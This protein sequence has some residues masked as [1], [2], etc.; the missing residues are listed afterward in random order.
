VYWQ[1]GEGLT[2]VLLHGAGDQ[3]GTWSEIVPALLEEYRLL[4]PDLPGHGESEPAQGPLPMDEIFAGLE[5]L[6]AAQ[7]G[8]SPFI[9]VGNSMG[10][11]LATLQA[12]RH[13]E[14]VSRAVLVNG[15]ALSGDPQNPSLTPVD[16]EAARQLMDLLRDPASPKIPGF[17][18]DDIVRRSASGPIGRMLQDMDSLVSNLMDGRLGEI[19]TPMD[20]VWGESDRLMSLSYAERM[21]AELPRARLTG[22]PA[23]GHIPQSECPESLT[24]ALLSVL[25]SEPPVAETIVE[26]PDEAGQTAEEETTDDDSR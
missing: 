21:L 19:S 14:S 17:V 20:M 25:E 7:N 18:L 12:H 26:P 3:A 11:W 2:L 22:V 6:L 1:G 5:A 13:P 16:R 15:G 8:D 23:C 9:L 4:I 24:E 10:A